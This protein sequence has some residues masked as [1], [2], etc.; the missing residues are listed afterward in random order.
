VRLACADQPGGSSSRTVVSAPAAGEAIVMS[1]MRLLTRC[2]AMT[3]APSA[4][5]PATYGA[6][7]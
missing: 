2:S 1:R 5:A 4:A 6:V 7:A 3:W